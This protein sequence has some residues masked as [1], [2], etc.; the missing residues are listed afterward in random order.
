MS[1]VPA[2][3]DDARR[4]DA[5]SRDDPRVRGERGDRDSGH[6]LVHGVFGNDPQLPTIT[7]YNHPTC[8]RPRASE[9][10]ESGP[11]HATRR[12]IAG[13][14]RRTT[15]AGA[16]ALYGI[17]AARAASVAANLRVLWEM[18]EEIGS[19]N[20]S[21]AARRAR[22]WRRTSS[23]FPTPSGVARSPGLSGRPARFAGFTLARD[24]RGPAQRR[25]RRRGAQSSPAD[26]VGGGVFRRGRT[27]AHPGFYDDMVPP[28]R[29]LD[30]FRRS[31]S[32]SQA[33]ATTA[34]VR[35]AAGIPRR[36]ASHLGAAHVRSSRCRRE[37]HRTGREDRRA[38]AG[39]GEDLVSPRAN[40]RGARAGCG[41]ALCVSATPVCACIPNN[42]SE[43]SRPRRWSA[44]RRRAPRD[45]VRIRSCAGS[46][47]R[48]DRLAPW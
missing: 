7:I 34:S 36:D 8:S 14:G 4:R 37:L 35:F 33:F 22:S 30:D 19:P 13:A 3:R 26:A 27:R 40:Q 23:S 5:R 16:A 42:A 1:A 43:P 31:G 29:R 48:V 9:P 28:T 21:K 11:V 10:W 41:E 15:G 46:C 45:R 6:P 17:V 12:A 2:H 20:S 39:R 47:G 24:G 38:A 44:R 25:R 32:R 18:E